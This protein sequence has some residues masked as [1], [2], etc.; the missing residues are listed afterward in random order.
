MDFFQKK[1]FFGHP[2]TFFDPKPPKNLKKVDF[3]VFRVAPLNTAL[4]FYKNLTFDTQSSWLE[5]YIRFEVNS[6]SSI[7]TDQNTSNINYLIIF[8]G[9]VFLILVFPASLQV[10]GAA[11][12]GIF[13]VPI[14]FSIFSFLALKALSIPGSV[15]NLREHLNQ[16]FKIEDFNSI[17]SF[18]NELMDSGL[19]SSCLA[20]CMLQLNGLALGIS[21]CWRSGVLPGKHRRSA[22]IFD[23]ICDCIIMFIFTTI[24]GLLIT[25]IV[26]MIMPVDHKFINLPS[27]S[28]P[29]LLSLVNYI[30]ID[31][32]NWSTDQTVKFFS[33]I[34]STL[35]LVQTSMSLL[36]VINVFHGMIVE[37][38]GAN[39]NTCT[40]DGQSAEEIM[41][42]SNPNRCCLGSSYFFSSCLG[43]YIARL[44]AAVLLAA[45]ALGLT[46]GLPNILNDFVIQILSVLTEFIWPITISTMTLAILIG[47]FIPFTTIL[48]SHKNRRALN[49]GES[50]YSINSVLY[51]CLPILG[52]V[53]LSITLLPALLCFISSYYYLSR[54][55]L[56]QRFMNFYLVQPVLRAFNPS[57]TNGTTTTD[58]FEMSLAPNI[59]AWSS[60]PSTS[61]SSTNNIILLS[62]MLTVPIL[63]I[64]L[65]LLVPCVSACISTNRKLTK[66]RKI[67]MKNSKDFP[68]TLNSNEISQSDKYDTLLTSTE[69]QRQSAEEALSRERLQNLD[70]DVYSSLSHRQ[71]QSKNIGKFGNFY[72]VKI[73]LRSIK[74]SFIPPEE[75][76]VSDNLIAAGQ[77]YHTL[78][79]VY[80]DK[81]PKAEMIPADHFNLDMNFYDSSD[82]NRIIQQHQNSLSGIAG[83]GS[84]RNS[85]IALHFTTTV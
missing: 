55:I 44:L 50:Y 76:G 28:L 45:L 10:R 32:L 62:I 2:D 73:F 59:T 68:M 11:W 37:L 65:L 46:V 38:L 17:A 52:I 9:L 85:E 53:I 75:A 66:I 61:I 35:L 22:P 21:G 19:V 41:A 60:N 3:F 54:S 81:G 71:S 8:L 33:I 20:Q 7:G 77:S 64:I 13:T 5:S 31:D 15:T 40:P 57:A 63:L 56:F 72:W 6:P 16:K 51:G 69:D 67:N 12:L 83:E 42:R 29:V 27:K 30:P 39:A 48:S 78:D 84:N 58:D 82:T 18:Q 23:L 80:P 79:K 24:G 26:C 43:R 1:F 47:I 70:Y 4:I 74:Y 36:P 49:S 34:I 14:S 25:I